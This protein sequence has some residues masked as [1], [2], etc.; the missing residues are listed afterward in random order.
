[1]QEMWANRH[2][3][4]SWKTGTFCFH[5]KKN[6][7][8]E[9]KNYRPIA[10]LEGV[11]KLYTSL[12]A[13]M[14]GDFCETQGILAQAQEGSRKQRNTLRQLTR[15]TNAIEDANLS[16]QELHGMYIDFENAYGSV[17]H[18]KLLGIM[19][20]LGIP[21]P[22][23]EV[24][25]NILGT[26]DYDTMRM[27]ARVG[28]HTSSEEVYVRRGLLQGDSMSPLLFILYQEPLLRWLETGENGYVHK[29]AAD[30]DKLGKLRTA[31]GAFVDDLLIVT[32]TIEKMK[33]QA[34]KLEAYSDWSDLKINLGKSAL[35]G[36]K[37]GNKA[38]HREVHEGV[39]I[40]GADGKRDR[41]TILGPNKPYK[42][43]GVLLTMTGN[44]KD[45]KE[46]TKK[47]VKDRVAALMKVPLT[48][49]QKEYSLH[50]AILG[51]FRYG[52]HLG[53]Y[54][55]GEIK[56]MEAILGGGQKM[57][58][59]L[60]RA[61]TPNI[62]TT[63]EKQKYGLG[64]EP[65]SA[66]YAQTVFSSLQEAVHSEEGKGVAPTPTNRERNLETRMKMS[67][68]SRSTR[69]LIEYHCAS[70]QNYTH[71]P[72]LWGGRQTKY[73]TLR[74]LNALLQHRITL[75]GVGGMLGSLRKSTPEIM[76][77]L[78]EATRERTL[79]EKQ[80]STTKTKR[81]Q[82]E[83]G[84]ITNDDPSKPLKGPR[85]RT[86]APKM[87]PEGLNFTRCLT[88]FRHFG[89]LTMLKSEDGRTAISAERL[90]ARCSGRTLLKHKQAIVHGMQHLYPY[91]C[92]AVPP[93]LKDANKA[94]MN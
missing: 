7:P 42:Y 20:Y 3:P 30:Q 76:R 39:T 75:K 10:L 46:S 93:D 13:D 94:Y 68:V 8:T 53:I 22:L 51:K 86:V 57:S 14:L 5:H 72:Q 84:E 17:D 87:D 23:I 16:G 70:R 69:G 58:Q 91:I 81:G 56:D 37:H 2:T 66:V 64:M 27:R 71:L 49:D 11:F 25:E 24:V 73:N 78:R 77:Q 19:E 79:K 82:I 88:L 92:E 55:K 15:V 65:L 63:L 59:G 50:S 6:D 36:V 12:I 9:Q 41:L 43:L 34:A 4:V 21:K 85:T 18:K 67:Q 60:P 47:A 45:E 26:G 62:F 52:L 33:L 40:K 38:I 61:G 1:M 48:P 89:N 83:D 35:T 74:K 28:R 29:Y 31:S 32:P 54:T 80:G 90:G 44:W